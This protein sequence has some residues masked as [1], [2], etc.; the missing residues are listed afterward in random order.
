MQNILSGKQ[1]SHPISRMKDITISYYSKNRK[2]KN[3]TISAFEQL[4]LLKKIGMVD[5]RDAQERIRASKQFVAGIG[6]WA[7]AARSLPFTCILTGALKEERFRD[8]RLYLKNKLKR[9]ALV[10]LGCGETPLGVG[11]ALEFAVTAR[12]EAYI[13]VDKYKLPENG[14]DLPSGS[15][16]KVAFVPED[17]LVF[18]SRLSDNSVNFL[19]SG[20]DWTIIQDHE[21]WQRLIKEI[22]RAT[23]KGGIVVGCGSDIVY[24]K[25]EAFRQITFGN[26]ASYILEKD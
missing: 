4:T 1:R 11:S 16:M 13:G 22:G 9:T 15:K 14:V 18:V 21:Y 23:I 12:V 17:M 19:M 10:D 26:T 25:P 24:M 20:I 6:D 8:E 3:R 5:N 2:V 7:G